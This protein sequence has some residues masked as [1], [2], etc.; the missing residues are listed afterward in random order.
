MQKTRKRR[1]PQPFFRKATKSWYV[2][3]G[4]R[5]VPL[6]PDKDAAW[7]EYHRLMT[8]RK[9]IEATADAT[10]CAVLE[11][12]LDWVKDWRSAGTYRWYSE[13]LSKFA[14]HI[15]TRLKLLELRERHVT[16]WIDEQYKGLAPDTIYGAIRAVQR[17]MNWA[18]KRGYIPK[19]PLKDIEKP[20][21]RPRETVITPDQF[22]EILARCADEEARDLFTTLWETGCRVQEI[23]HVEAANFNEADHCWNFPREKSKGKRT[24]RTIYLTPTSLDIT[25][26]LA[27]KYPTR[28]IFRNRDGKPW[29]TNAIVLRFQRAAK[30]LAKACTFCDGTAIAF[31]R[32]PHVPQNEKLGRKRRYACQDCITARKLTRKMLGDIP[33]PIRGLEDACPTSFRHSFA[34]RALKNR[35]AGMTLSVLLGHTDTR[36]VSRVYGHLEQDPGFLR[37]ELQRATAMKGHTG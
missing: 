32:G 1:E 34:T 19:S 20:Q 28:P 29:K 9:D 2:Q 8:E 7:D 13:N 14:R 27:A 33:L 35:V 30:P 6:G 17:A 12:F 26:R 31:V 24:P 5:Q 37:E 21:Q 18:V 36:M 10:V 3:L 15:G 23:R 22:R 25:A 4:R 16:A 11:A